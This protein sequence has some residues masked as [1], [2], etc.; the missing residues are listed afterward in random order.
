MV[1]LS[2]SQKARNRA[3][4]KRFYVRSSRV[5]MTQTPSHSST[6]SSDPCDFTGHLSGR[7]YNSKCQNLL[8]GDF[9]R[10][11]CMLIVASVA[12]FACVQLA[13]PRS[14]AAV[15]IGAI[16]RTPQPITRPTSLLSMALCRP[17]P[18]PKKSFSS[19]YPGNI[20]HHVYSEELDASRPQS[21]HRLCSWPR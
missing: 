9:L 11:L 20:P 3:N 13:N 10:E 4:G 17:F 21:F 7:L 19:H 1:F 5:I 12:L 8:I 15:S 14:R 6:F 16:H 2:H 18:N